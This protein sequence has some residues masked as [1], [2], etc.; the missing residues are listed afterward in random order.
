MRLPTWLIAWTTLLTVCFAAASAQDK[1]TKEDKSAQPT[2]IPVWP[3]QAPGSENWTQKET[4]F[5]FDKEK[6]KSI[7]NVVR[8]TLTA[9]LPE[10]SKANGT[11][12]IVCPGGG[13]H[14]LSWEGEGTE[15]A[16]WLRARGVAAFV[17]KYRV[18]DT[19][20]TEEDFKKTLKASMWQAIVEGLKVA[21]S[22]R[23]PA[24]PEAVRKI[25]ALAI[26]DARQAIKVVRT[27]AGKW[28]VKPDRVGIMGFS[29]GGVVTIGVATGYDAASRPNFAAPIYGSVYSSVK[30][31]RDAPP[32]FICCA[33]DDAL[34]QP[35]DSISLYSSWQRA[36]KSAELH[37]YARGNHGFGMSK[38]GLPCDTWI[39]R[40]GDWLGQQ[41]FLKP[42]VT[43]PTSP[44]SRHPAT[45]PG[46]GRRQR[47]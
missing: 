29:A 6:P 37:V 12:V 17:L 14:F 30:V 44:P 40:F 18:M 39:D 2:V 19:G 33:S 11:A 13:F 38:Q 15:V 24:L 47:P 5:H 1:D 25:S 42:A 43:G 21:G 16:E 34:A 28:G 4:E 41:G 3:K 32:L 23:H 20:A 31:P 36:A 22:G 10:E 45:A 8:P 35:G 9:F 46:P 27:H 26:A 7:R